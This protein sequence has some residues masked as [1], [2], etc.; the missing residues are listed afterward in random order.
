MFILR[1]RARLLSRRR[2]GG[3]KLMHAYSDLIDTAIARIL[4]L[5]V[6]ETAGMRSAVLGGVALTAT[7]GYGRR[8]MS[9][10]SDID[11]AFVVADEDDPQV[12]L[13]VKNAYRLLMDSLLNCAGL[14]V[15][16]SY[17]QL[18]DPDD[19]PLETHT[20]LLD[21]RLVAGSALL[22]DRFHAGVLN[23]L[24]PAVFVSEHLR[25][26][27]TA[28]SSPY[29]VEANVKEGSGGLRDLHAARWIVQAAFG[30][31]R[32]EVWQA[33]RAHGILADREIE[34]VEDAAEFLASVRN[35][36]HAASGR[37]NDILSVDRQ[38]E[39]AAKLG[40]RSGAPALMEKYFRHTEHVADILRK[41]AAACHEETLEIEPGLV[42]Q[43]GEI[44]LPDKQLL[45]RDPKAVIRIFDHAV[46]S[47]LGI[48]RETADLIREHA[49]RRGG[50]SAGVG[51]AFLGLL[52]RPD[53]A[54]A[55]DVMSA[56]GVLKWLIPEFGRL[57]Y[58][59]PGDTAHE[60]TVG[61]HSLEV[62]RQLHSSA[63]GSDAELRDVSAG[64][65]RP[66]LLYLAAL[67][68]DIGKA[69]M[70]GHHAEQGAPV[71]GMI[72]RRLG[73]RP[74]AVEQLEFLVRN[75]LVMAETARLRD[76]N[77]K[78]TVEDFVSVVDSIELLDML[79]LLTVADIKS[80]GQANWSEVQLSFLCELYH[81]ASMALR[82]SMPAQ[83]DIERHR[84][85]LTREL[86]LSNI[87]SAEVEE[88][89]RAMPAS[90]LLNTSA[91]DLAAHIAYVRSSRAGKPV[92]R[93]R[94]DMTRRFTE[95]TVCTLD[96]PA[97][98]LLARIAGAL[99]AFDV[100][101]HAAQVFTREA[102]DRIA[103]DLLSVDFDRRTLPE[104]KRL[105]VQSELE[106]VL[107]GEFDVDALLT[108]FGKKLKGD[109]RLSKLEIMSHLSDQHTVIE[110]EADD[111]PGL[112]YR[113][114]RAV[115]FL[116]W[117]IHSARVA[118]WGNRARDVFYVTDES[119][120]KLDGMPA[121]DLRRAVERH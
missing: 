38:D 60:M 62:V 32:E 108:R 23:A 39:I 70:T 17:R 65:E 26:R 72:A 66:E 106:K 20:A 120:R 105:Q 112:L 56:M 88:H 9:P 104:L 21:A 73:L 80:V 11:I 119:G 44:H 49:G 31:P 55:L 98:G 37:G 64:I 115:S 19:L 111:R 54:Q 69:E 87:P 78:R 95:I 99:F 27:K 103:I 1:E 94:D 71:A 117:N 34:S 61:A 77:E 50:R 57:M 82:S 85:R 83:V 107:R 63:A 13:L 86:S 40:F 35:A 8:E 6:E 7:G 114:T 113:L 109:V 15:G 10:F 58:V 75:H 46:A 14:K 47:K 4:Q 33:L 36:L 18:G 53:A 89:C 118:T 12:D 28:G 5:A 2:P 52:S 100:E 51:R 84:S 79:Y 59:V 92:V 68:H 3:R 42:V 74:E 110:I 93:L 30:V 48:G 91:D 25:R 116:R 96:G 24:V 102:S 16:Y 121:F 43:R 67:L 45:S 29:R 76:L 81:R 101:I 41:I 90:Y 22:F 97:P